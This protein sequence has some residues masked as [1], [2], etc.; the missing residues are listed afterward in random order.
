MRGPF[1]RGHKMVRRAV[2]VGELVGS[3]KFVNQNTLVANQPR[4]DR[5]RQ[6]SVT[7]F[8][9]NR[10]RRNSVT[11]FRKNKLRR[12]SVG[13]FR[14]ILVKGSHKNKSRENSVS[15]MAFVWSVPHHSAI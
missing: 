11:P 3:G 4:K 14:K 12:S 15:V 6:S 7:L 10:I 1:K 9:K 5:L 13:L 2:L 8:R